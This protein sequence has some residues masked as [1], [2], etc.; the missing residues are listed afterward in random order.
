[1]GQANYILG[2]LKPKPARLGVRLLAA[3]DFNQFG[4]TAI[5]G[6]RPPVCV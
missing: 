6:G 3:L 4:L 1:M 5:N 2:E